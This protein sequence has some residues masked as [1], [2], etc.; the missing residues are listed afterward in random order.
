MSRN[1]FTLTG[2]LLISNI[3]VVFTL[4]HF[5][6]YCKDI[7][8]ESRICFNFVSTLFSTCDTPFSLLDRTKTCIVLKLWAVSLI[9]KLIEPSLHYS[10][11]SLGYALDAIVVGKSSWCYFAL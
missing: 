3:C 1:I 9:A 10:C 5:L 2:C 7:S 11:S 4:L 6:A 8:I